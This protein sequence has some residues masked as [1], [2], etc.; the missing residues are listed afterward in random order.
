MKYALT[1]SSALILSSFS[2]L[3]YSSPYNDCLLKNMKNSNDDITIE[4]LRA[5]C[6]QVANLQAEPKKTLAEQRLLN[7]KENAFNP[8][9]ITP[10]QMNY[11]LPITLTDSINRQPYNDYTEWG[12]GLQKEEAK[13]Q[14]SFKVPL[15]FG[16]T[17]VKND[18]FYLGMTLKSWWQ[19]YSKDIS[20]PFR[21]TNYK[22][23]IFYQAPLFSTKKGAKMWGGLGLEHESNGRQQG[24]SRSWNRIYAFIGYEKDNYFIYFKPWHRIE[25]DSKD[26]PLSSEGDDNP[27]IID[28]FG[29]YELKG[30]YKHE[31][32]QYS[33][34]LRENFATHKGYI[35]S[36]VTFPLW[37]RLRGYVQYTS[38]YGESLIDYNHSQQTIGVGLALTDN[39]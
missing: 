33:V 13:F 24:L 9:I 3:S 20:S 19:V 8:F 37:G 2:S 30:I 16:D 27:D 34:L 4:Q 1:L 31:K 36:G 11:I 7:E 21:E 38:G 15:T 35:E 17:F 28:Y 12:G 14:M 25:E 26:Y 39:L 29:H 32:L 6:E 23:E 18:G 5:Q 22:P 10:H